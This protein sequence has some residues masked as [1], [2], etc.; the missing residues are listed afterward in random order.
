ML[1]VFWGG[2]RLCLGK[3]MAAL[4]TMSVAWSIMQ[5]FKVQ[6]LPFDERIVNG[7]VMFFE[8]GMPAKFIRRT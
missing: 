3:D 5:H 2:P 7:P 1:P 6:V 8:H 4:E